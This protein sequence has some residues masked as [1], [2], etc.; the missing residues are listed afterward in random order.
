MKYFNEEGL[1]I[2]GYIKEL[3]HSFN[4]PIIPVLTDDTIPYEGRT[5][6]KE[7]NVV[8]YK[9][10]DLKILAPY[11][12][13]RNIVNITKQLKMNSSVYDTYTHEYLGEYL[14]FMRDYKHLDLMGMYNCFSERMPV[15][16]EINVQVDPEDK[17][18]VISVDTNNKNYSY[19]IVPIKFNK[20]YTIAMDSEVRYELMSILY[21]NSYVNTPN[22]LIKESYM[23]VSGSKF[24]TPF[25]YSTYFNSASKLWAK[26]Q[27]LCLLFKIP[28]EVKSSIVVLEG[29][30][31]DSANV[32]DGTYIN[33]M[34]YDDSAID[35]T[36]NYTAKNFLLWANN[37]V[38]YPF[39]PRLIEYLL[40]NAITNIDSI[41]NNIERVQ[42]TIFSKGL[43][44]YYGI[45]DNKLRNTIYSEAFKRDKTLGNSIKKGN[46][47]QMYMPDGGIIINQKNPKR[48][49]D[50][51][52]NILGYV[53]KDIE[54]LLRLM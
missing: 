8:K 11:V 49:I 36:L 47:I 7:Q 15:R 19:Y 6:I 27:G 21:S 40:F 31:L 14:R 20:E 18:K 24:R 5:Y 34:I 9:D 38:N 17:T 2:T 26:E 33:K 45:W 46:T 13:N 22:N 10:G 35:S 32:I 42:D 25:L 4:L 41:K 50:I 12:F 37:K 53:D 54:S 3:L 39:A 51:Y 1:I 52:E 28:S 23:S 29:N 16:V 44:G 30:Y 48:F 43:E